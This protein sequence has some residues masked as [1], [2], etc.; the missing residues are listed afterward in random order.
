MR[1]DRGGLLWVTLAGTDRDGKGGG[2]V[3]RGWEGAGSDRWSKGGGVD[4]GVG[5]AVRC[6]EGDVVLLGGDAPGVVRRDEVGPPAG[7][8][9]GERRALRLRGRPRGRP[10]RFDEA[11]G[12]PLAKVTGTR[13]VEVKAP[14]SASHDAVAALGCAC[15]H[16][17]WA[18][19]ASSTSILAIAVTAS[20]RRS[21]SS[22]SRRRR[23]DAGAVSMGQ[24]TRPSSRRKATA[25]SDSIQRLKW[26]LI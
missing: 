9:S 17:S 4:V 26:S 18:W 6:C 22:R 24:R 3:I 20:S 10:G 25:S 5:G 15:C 16:A 23:S 12:G 13:I 1:M 2:G 7:D 21:F 14:S 11:Y 8:T 19:S